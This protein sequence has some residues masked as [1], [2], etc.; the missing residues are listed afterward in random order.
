M[1]TLPLSQISFMVNFSK[2]YKNSY[3]F[4]DNNWTWMEK[5]KV[6]CGRERTKY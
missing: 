1:D 2:G 4:R 5:V 6:F 3:P